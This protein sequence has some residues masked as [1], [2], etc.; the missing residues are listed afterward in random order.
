MLDG[1]IYV[2]CKSGMIYRFTN[3]DPAIGFTWKA[4]NTTVTDLH[5]FSVRYDDYRRY[6]TITLVVCDPTNVYEIDWSD[7]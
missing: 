2:L 3:F 5:D 6:N 4:F 1:D 7:F